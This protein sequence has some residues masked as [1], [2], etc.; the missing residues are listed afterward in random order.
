MKTK[1]IIIFLLCFLSLQL[2]AESRLTFIDKRIANIGKV[3]AGTVVNR[4][5]RF[6]NDGDS[7]LIIIEAIKSCNCTAVN[8]SKKVLNPGETGS[9]EVKIDTKNK[10]G[11]NVITVVIEANTEQREY[12]LRISMDVTKKSS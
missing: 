2:L 10:L 8:F 4:K 11:T 1:I 9:I 7:P 5:I 3:E 12:A 6:K